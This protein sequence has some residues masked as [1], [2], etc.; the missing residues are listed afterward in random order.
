M[1]FLFLFL[2]ILESCSAQTCRCVMERYLEKQNKLLTR[3]RDKIK[4]QN[5]RIL[6][7]SKLK[8]A[9]IGELK[10]QNE[11]LKKKLE[12]A[13][14]TPA[15]ENGRMEEILKENEELRIERDQLKSEKG[16]FC[17]EYFDEID[18]L[19]VKVENGIEEIDGL[20]SQN[21]KL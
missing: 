5:Q 16:R 7:E 2:I 8:E 10:R 17:N 1:N 18:E 4:R 20:K 6:E 15:P 14:K 3:E 9:E 13:L 11:K 12:D 19:N 21:E